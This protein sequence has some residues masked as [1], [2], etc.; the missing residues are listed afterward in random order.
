MKRQYDKC[1]SNKCQICLSQNYQAH[2]LFKDTLYILG[3][4][5]R[6][7]IALTDYL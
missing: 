4:E 2:K 6:E 1:Y 3:A 7:R 5:D